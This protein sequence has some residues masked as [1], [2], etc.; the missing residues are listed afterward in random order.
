MLKHQKPCNKKRCR[1]SRANELTQQKWIYELR[2]QVEELHTKLSDKGEDQLR[3]R[4]ALT[5]RTDLIKALSWAM[6]TCSSI[7]WSDRKVYG[8]NP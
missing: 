2:R 7:A 1:T 4:D 5:A 8:H 3:S 6:K